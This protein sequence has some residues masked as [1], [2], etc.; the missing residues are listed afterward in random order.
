M[1]TLLKRNSS[2]MVQ[3]AR[4]DGTRPTVT[5]GKVPKSVALTF[6]SRIESL[7]ACRQFNV[8]IDRDLT[9][10]IISLDPMMQLRLAKVGLVDEA[11]IA[12]VGPFFQAWLKARESKSCK[13]TQ[14]RQQKA[15]EFL[16]R[17]VGTDTLVCKVTEADA[18]E[19]R[20]KLIADGYAEATT[21]KRCSDIKSMFKHAIDRHVISRNPFDAVATAA[22]ATKNKVFVNDDVAAAILEQ[23]TDPTLRLMFLLSRYGGLRLPSEAKRMR[24]EDIDFDNRRMLIHGKNNRE[25]ICPLWPELESALTEMFSN[26][27][28]GEPRVLPA[29][30]TRS[31]TVWTE[32]LRQAAKLAGVALWKRPWHNMRSTRQT[33]LED[34]FPGHVVCAWVGNTEQVAAKHYLQVTDEHFEQATRAAELHALGADDGGTARNRYLEK[35]PSRPRNRDI[36]AKTNPHRLVGVSINDPNG[37]VTPLAA[38]VLK[39]NTTP[40][41]RTADQLRRD[42]RAAKL[43]AIT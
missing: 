34:R 5:I 14:S 36:G 38:L 27:P 31:H 40:I 6:K 21:R 13:A 2:Y 30:P 43:C 4:G 20:N 42:Y 9:R 37:S 19:V 17:C 23:I 22:T 8:S 29:L 32:R 33:E 12:R 15:H 18:I 26:A 41:L 35:Q 7:L 16:C 11:V 25:R 3:L 28:E 24:W 10:W 39:P 1:A